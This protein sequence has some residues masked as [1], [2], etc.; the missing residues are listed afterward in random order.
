LIIT[1]LPSDKAPDAVACRVPALG[2]GVALVHA[3]PL[4]VRIFPD[5]PGEVIPVPPLAAG[6]VPVT[7]VVRLM[8]VSV[9]L[10]PLTV[11]LVSVC[12]LDAVSTLLGVMMLDRVAIVIP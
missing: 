5:V 10:A 11:L 8:F 1:V 12:V 2:A 3:G 9:L 6:N 4:E 7:A